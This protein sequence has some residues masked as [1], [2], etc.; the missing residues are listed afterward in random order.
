MTAFKNRKDCDCYYNPFYFFVNMPK[1]RKRLLIRKENFK[2][3]D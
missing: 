2:A 1:L 3:Q